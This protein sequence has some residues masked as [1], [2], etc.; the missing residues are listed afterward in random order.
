V[1][2]VFWIIVAGGFAALFGVLMTRRS[3]FTATWRR[4]RFIETCRNFHWQRE[5][6]EARFVQ[7]SQSHSKPGSPRWADCDFSDDVS[8]VRNRY[9]G[10][11]S[12][13]VA[14]T[15]L[16]EVPQVMHEEE[17]SRGEDGLYGED[18]AYGQERERNPLNLGSTVREATAVFR[19]ERDRWETDGRAIFNLSPSETIRFYQ[20]DLEMVG[21]ELAGQR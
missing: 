5:H 15:I 4:N 9:T 6:L 21:Q 7:I 14:V 20:H 11:L 1:G 16:L 12:A 18:C 3:P 8:Y 10:E 13:F 17:S 19:F 2:G